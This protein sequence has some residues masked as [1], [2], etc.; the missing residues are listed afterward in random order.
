V[1][2][3]LPTGAGKTDVAVGYILDRMAA[4][5]QVRVIWVADQVSLLEQAAERFYAAARE[6]PDGFDRRLRLFVEGRSS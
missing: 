3:A 5:R 4:D 6:R 1:L 2:V